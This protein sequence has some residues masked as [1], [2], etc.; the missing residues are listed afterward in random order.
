[1]PETITVLAE[2][3]QNLDTTCYRGT[4]ALADLCR[5]SQPDIFDQV[6][7]PD[8]LQRDLNKRH[9]L[10]AYEYV[11]R[12][13]APTRPRAFP[14]VMLNV[15]DLK[16][17]EV[18]E[19]ADVEGLKV[20]SIAFDLDKIDR[21]KTVK[22]SRVDGN[23]RLWFGNGD[24]I[25][26]PP[27]DALVPFSIT[28][29]LD[30]DQEG[31]LFLDFN[32]EQK[33]LNTSHLHV[34]RSRLTP[35]EVELAQHPERVYALHLAS[36]A[37]SPWY[38]LVHMGG[39]KA[40][41]QEQGVKRPVNFVALEQGI[42]R[43]LS[44]SQ[45][46]TDLTTYDAQYG[47]LRNYWQAVKAVFPEAWERPG[48]YLVLKNLGVSVFSLV[49]AAVI[50]RCMA[51]MGDYIEIE[52]MAAYLERAKKAVDW[53]K[54]SVDVAGMSGN[55]AALALA[56]RMAEAMPKRPPKARPQS[57]IDQDAIADALTSE[58]AA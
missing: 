43:T 20:V 27:L 44:K 15:R 49:G 30:R 32:S 2:E 4:A 37:A 58:D 47:L 54:D 48:D 13:A 29:G 24:G 23:H 6:T 38:D 33:G 34:L 18:L 28:L 57:V 12:E 35:D 50:D 5:L 31:S 21:A 1:M 19:L 16:V 25:D 14:E 3:S 17:V 42:K 40:G 51:A 46:I 11:A 9:A 39:S 56:G 10:D 55:R 41:S 26:R 52:T 22:V 8:G 7:H 53:H 36:D 45:Y